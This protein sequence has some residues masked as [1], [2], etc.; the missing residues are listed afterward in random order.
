MPRILILCFA[1]VLTACAESQQAV[2]GVARRS[3]KAAVEKTLATRFPGVP[4]AAVTPF[5]DCVIENS[6]GRE[7]AEFAKDAVVGV[8]ETTVS[9]VQGV[10]SRSETQACVAAAGLAALGL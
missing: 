1:L 7:I 8:S 10:L 6:S 2:D 5:S 9:L 4:T 3:A